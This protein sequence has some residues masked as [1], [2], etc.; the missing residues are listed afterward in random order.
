MAGRSASHQIGD[1][2]VEDSRHEYPHRQSEGGL[3][4]GRI[5]VHP[6]NRRAGG[7]VLRNRQLFAIEGKSVGYAGDVPFFSLRTRAAWHISAPL[8][9]T[10]LVDSRESAVHH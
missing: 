10:K 1:H 7:G 4:R 3:T 6:R 9:Q 8:G 2:E 5:L